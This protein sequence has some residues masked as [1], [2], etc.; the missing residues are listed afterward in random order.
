MTTVKTRI[1]R[2]D[3]LRMKVTPDIMERLDKISRVLGVPP[4]TL[5]AVA[6]GQWVAQQERSFMMTESL[7]NS[8]GAKLGDELADQ[9]RE[10]MGQM[11]LFAKDGG[12]DA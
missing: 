1:K 8:L 5:C 3:S 2:G 7:A 4:S 11:G 9:F 6:V 12:G 10:Q